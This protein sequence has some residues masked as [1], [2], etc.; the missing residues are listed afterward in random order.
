MTNIYHY[1]RI[2]KSYANVQ[3]SIHLTGCMKSLSTHLNQMHKLLDQLIET[4]KAL[5]ELS[6]QVVSEEELNSLQQQQKELL[7]QL[8]AS[9]QIIEADYRNQMEEND[10]RNVSNK[11]HTFQSLNHDFIQNLQESHGLIQFE[12]SHLQ[13]QEEEVEQF[14]EQLNKVKPSRNKKK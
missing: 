4:A 13:Q 8:E 10:H 9:D 12:L 5:K 14:S 7:S 6:K 1:R 3:E 2:S 11:L